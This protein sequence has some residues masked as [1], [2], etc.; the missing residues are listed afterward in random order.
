MA[1]GILGMAGVFKWTS[2]P[3]SI[4][5]FE[6]LG[7]EPWGRYLMGT[8]ELVTTLLLLVPRTAA[9]GGLA[10]MGLMTGAIAVH[11]FRIGI[12]YQGDASLF[13]MAVATFVAGLVVLLIRRR[14]AVVQP[15]TD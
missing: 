3:E 14:G 11:L 10:A 12:V 13:M 7:A 6:Q 8:A 15:A 4:R 2:A 9:W 1:T 5:L